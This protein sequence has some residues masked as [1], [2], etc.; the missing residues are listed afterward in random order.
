MS[1]IEAILK[2]FQ[3]CLPNCEL[4]CGHPFISRSNIC[5]CHPTMCR[6]PAAQQLQF[7]LPGGVYVDAPIS[8]RYSVDHIRNSFYPVTELWISLTSTRRRTAHYVYRDIT[9]TMHRWPYRVGRYEQ[10]EWS[11]WTGPRCCRWM[12][13]LPIRLAPFDEMAPRCIIENWPSPMFTVY[14]PRTGRTYQTTLPVPFIR[15][16]SQVARVSCYLKAMAQRLPGGTVALRRGLQ[17]FLYPDNEY[18][19]WKTCTFTTPGYQHVS[20]QCMEYKPYVFLGIGN[21]AVIAPALGQWPASVTIELTTP[22]YPVW[23]EPY[24]NVVITD[25]TGKQ[26]TVF[27]SPTRVFVTVDTMRH[28]DGTQLVATT[29]DDKLFYI[30]GMKPKRLFSWNELNTDPYL[31]PFV[32]QPEE[33]GLS[34]ELWYEGSTGND[35]G[36]CDQ[37]SATLDLKLNT[38]P[39]PGPPQAT[40]VS[41]P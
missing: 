6:T 5:T 17:R 12:S 38:G 36:V 40:I 15:S 25:D 35:A 2:L 23:P 41:L 29:P 30:T 20:I 19:T 26:Y 14:V 22:P 28:E 9:A 24:E 31:D 18:R 37:F 34:S 11:D 8:E 16:N 21:K 39:L 32:N 1:K 3:K 13:R 10:G 33:C 7:D 4:P 27:G